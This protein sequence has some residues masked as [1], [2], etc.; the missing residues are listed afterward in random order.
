MAL[1]SHLPVVET[2]VKPDEDTTGKVCIGREI[3]EELDYTPAKLQV[4]RTIRPKYITREDERGNQKQV[5]AE[6]DRPIPKCIASPALLS[7]I[8]TNKYIYHLPL[9][10]TRQM[11]ARMGVSLPPFQNR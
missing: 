6:L 9:Y 8:F 1:P 4:N 7:M 5:I 11:I 2:V 10:R 3:T